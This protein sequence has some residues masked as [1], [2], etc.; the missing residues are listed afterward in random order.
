[1][2]PSPGLRPP[3]PRPE[4]VRESD[5]GNADSLPGSDRAGPRVCGR[6]CRL[7]GRPG[8]GGKGE[9]LYATK[10]PKGGSPHAG[11]C[12]KEFSVVALHATLRIVVSESPVIY[13][14][15]F[16]CR[17]QYQPDPGTSL[18]H[19]LSAPY[20]GSVMHPASFARSSPRTRRGSGPGTIRMRNPRPRSQSDLH[21]ALPGANAEPASSIVP[22]GGGFEGFNGQAFSKSLL[23]RQRRT[24]EAPLPVTGVPARTRRASPYVPI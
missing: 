11:C 7:R 8:S 17:Y 12:A 5:P 1:V 18:G 15:A 19:L 2:N 9:I 22:P 6:R 13:Q 20:R 16:R 24:P 3:S 14:G 21:A 23:S 4:T 10:P